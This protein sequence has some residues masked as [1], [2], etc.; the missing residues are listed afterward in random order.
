VASVRSDI[1]GVG[2]SRTDLFISP[3]S[4]CHF[5]RSDVSVSI[6]RINQRAM[7]LLTYRLL[8]RKSLREDMSLS[9]GVGH[10]TLPPSATYPRQSVA[11]DVAGPNHYG[12]KGECFDSLYI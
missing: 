5:G 11:W 2:P 7:N 6:I 12:G 9:R 10:L 3:N 8:A 4:L 1:C